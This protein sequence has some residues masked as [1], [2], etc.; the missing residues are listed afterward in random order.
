MASNKCRVCHCSFKTKFGNFAK[1]QQGHM[2]T[3]NLFTPS[4]RKD[5]VVLCW[6]ISWKVLEF[7]WIIAR[8]THIAFAILVAEKSAIWALYMLWYTKKPG[9]LTKFHGAK[10]KRCQQRAKTREKNYFASVP[11][12]NKLWH[13]QHATQSTDLRVM[14]CGTRKIKG[15]INLYIELQE[16]IKLDQIA[17][18]NI[19]ISLDKPIAFSK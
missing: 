12:P 11:Q 4:N 16:H 8:P 9:N 5:C 3:E 2:S 13:I 19:R 6:Q 10:P 1:N 7:L 17:A 14:S 15:E 18:R